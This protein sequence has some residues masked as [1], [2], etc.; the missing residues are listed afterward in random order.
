VI[1]AR[2]QSEYG[3]KCVLEPLGHVAARWPVPASP[4]SSP[5]S[6]TTSGALLLKDRQGRDVIL[7]ESVWELRFVTEANPG[8]TFVDSM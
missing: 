8:Y 2:L 6:V 5:P 4:Q 3:I 7:F 1:E